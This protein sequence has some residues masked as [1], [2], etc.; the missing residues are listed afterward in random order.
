[1]GPAPG[2]GQSAIH[3]TAYKMADGLAEPLFNWIS[4]TPQGELIAT[5]FNA[6][7]A[8]ALD[9]YS[10]SNFPAPAEN[11]GRICESPGGQGWALVPSG[12]AEFKNNSWLP[13]PVPEIDAAF[14]PSHPHQGIVPALLPV[15]QG[16]VLFLLPDRLMEFLADD[17]DTSRT[18]LIKQ[19]A[20]TQIGD[21]SSM[22]GSPDE[23]LWIGGTRGLA[24]V[25]D[26]TG[27]KS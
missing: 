26:G 2:W 9:G 18:V 24:R 1:M 5:R 17:P 15:R 13:H 4:F 20:Q 16:S 23:G 3:W 8:S 7:L 27:A 10:V 22:A 25:N 14:H 21:F 19:A 12:L 11:L 6:P